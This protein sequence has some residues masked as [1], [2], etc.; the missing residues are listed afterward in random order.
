VGGSLAFGYYRWVRF[1]ST[2]FAAAFLVILLSVPAAFAGGTAT[3]RQTTAKDFEEGEATASVI[4]PTGEVVPGLK[5]VRVPLEATFVWS[6]VMASDGGTAYF[7]TGD[8]GRIYAV[9]AR[10]GTTAPAARKLADLDT[11]WVTALALRGDGMLLAGSTPGARVF[12]VDPARGTVKQLAKL[13]AE[14]IWALAHDADKKVTYAATGG[15]G[16]VFTIDAKGVVKQLWDSGDKQ[17][18]ALLLLP[19]GGFLAGTSSEG[20]LY[21]VTGDGQALALQDF[22]ADEVRAISRVGTTTYVAVNDFEG[23]ASEVASTASTPTITLESA[24]AS[25]ARGTRITLGSAGSG[26]PAAAGGGGRSGSAKGKGAVYR[27]EDAGTI[28]QV[29]A[30]SDGYL[31]ALLPESAKG[32]EVQMLVAAG[33]AGK[34]YRLLADRTFALAADLSERQALTLART[35]DGFLVGTGDSGGLYE[36]RPAAAGEA[37]YLSRVFDGEFPSQ[38]GRLHYTGTQ[39]LVFETR[40]GNTA[41]PDKTWTAWRRLADVTFASGEGQGRIASPRSRYVQ[42]KMSLPSRDS[43]LHELSLSY[44]PQN[45]RPVVTDVYL[46]DAPSPAAT[47]GVA[48]GSRS[49]SSVLKLRWRVENRDSDLL[50]YRLSYRQEKESVW[51]PLSGPEPLTKAEYDWNTDSVPDGQYLVRVWA[52]DERSNSGERALDN[53]FV[54]AP[55]LVD[56][57]RPEVRDLQFRAPLISGRASDGASVIAGVEYSVDGQ[58]WRPVSPSDGLFDQRAEAFVI[59]LPPTLGKGPHVFNVRAVDGA[60]NLGAGRIQVEIK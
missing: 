14:H 39:S 12:T 55:F 29:F 59:R 10:Q 38:W 51:R 52:T 56:N 25:A 49:H 24:A 35:A 28:E 22:D 43:R 18:V 2:G 21:R 3:F 30:L 48:V 58:D 53:T 15:P 60:D 31:T 5:A 26:A 57:T 23:G 41:K 11:P 13:P 54:S 42:Y 17:V 16:K 40:S 34:V 7:G 9:S 4:L 19:G 32:N 37:S 27:L 36:V 33:T 44:L 20:V 46:A 6:G 47:P 1:R 45:Q 50:L 8:Q